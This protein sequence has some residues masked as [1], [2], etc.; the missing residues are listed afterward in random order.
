MSCYTGMI[1]RGEGQ[2]R[3]NK[4]EDCD[5]RGCRLDT[6]VI[7]KDHKCTCSHGAVIGGQSLGIGNGIRDGCPPNNHVICKREV[8]TCVPN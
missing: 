5:P 1:M 7:C 2:F 3:C 4:A 6:H 8:C